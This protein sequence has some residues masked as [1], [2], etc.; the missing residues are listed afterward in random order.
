MPECSTSHREWNY[1]TE[2]ELRCKCGCGTCQMDDEAVEVFDLLRYQATQLWQATHPAKDFPFIV[3][4]G[5]RCLT[6]DSSP[7]VGGMGL[8]PKGCCLDTVI[9]SM[10]KRGVILSVA[11]SHPKI[12]GIGIA[13][14]FIHLDTI[15]RHERRVWTY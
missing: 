11:L 1:F 6:H 5:Y 13:H 14:N 3:T 4:S 12:M 10:K 8:H 15:P 2:D 7:E 9:W